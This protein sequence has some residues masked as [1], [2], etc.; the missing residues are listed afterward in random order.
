VGNRRRQG[1][2]D[3]K[4][5]RYDL[6]GVT[7]SLWFATEVQVLDISAGGMKV[8]T[9][10]HLEVGR[11]YQFRLHHERQRAVLYGRVVW[12][13]LKGS[14]RVDDDWI[15]PAYRAGV[16]FDLPADSEV[17]ALHDLIDDSLVID[18][19]HGLEGALGHPSTATAR[20]LEPFVVR[21]ISLSG[22]L[23]VVRFVPEIGD[24]F[25]LEIELR[26]EIVATRGVVT[27]VNIVDRASTTVEVGVKFQD[28][29]DE[30]L[31]KLRSF[32]EREFSEIDPGL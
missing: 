3:R 27:L 10:A 26:D 18:L 4:H 8:E 31:A 28:M 6:S 32:I 29:S 24:V 11:T 15:E 30:E 16:S 7:G 23:F 9:S 13:T 20:G 22:M 2:H 21:R 5:R 17:A 19:D 25:E 12:C 14:R 1:R